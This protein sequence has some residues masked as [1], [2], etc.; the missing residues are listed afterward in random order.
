MASDWEDDDEVGYGRPPHWTRFRK[1][2]SGNP[3]GR[4][5]KAPVTGPEPTESEADRLMRQE[6]DRAISITDAGGTRKAAMSEVVTRSL[7][8]NAAQGNVLAQRTV[9]KNQLELERRE[10]ERAVAR[11]AAEAAR[12]ERLYNTFSELKAIQ[13]QAWQQAAARGLREPEQPW[14]HPDDI[15]INHATLGCRIRGPFDAKDVP[16]FE[17]LRATRDACLLE[18]AIALRTRG[19]R[20]RRAARFKAM[21]MAMHDVLLP[22]RWQ[23]GD[24]LEP[25]LVALLGQPPRELRRRAAHQRQRAALLQPPGHHRLDKPTYAFIN[26]AMQ[27]L[28]RPLGYASLARF[29]RA[30]HDSGGDPPVPILRPAP[31]RRSRS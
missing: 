9:L 1:G 13:Q 19:P 7:M 2:Q 10:R 11:A 18:A 23:V 30:W 4:P 29:E 22:L 12:R 27:P 20:G 14:P 24:V 26:Q 21:L 28:L 16:L 25:M 3:R 17:Y 8:N 6:L 5:R 31:G 15:L